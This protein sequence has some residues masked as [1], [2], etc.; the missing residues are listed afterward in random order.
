MAFLALFST[1]RF[2]ASD[3]LRGVSVPTLVMHGDADSVVPYEQ[4]RALYERIEG[5]K[6][7]FTIAG[8]DHNDAAPPDEALYWRA[9]RDFIA[10]DDRGASFLSESRA[11]SPSP[12]PRGWA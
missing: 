5:P 2:P 4:G 8:G 1:Y 10:R 11:P 12:E 6:E 7:F 9:I 3:Y